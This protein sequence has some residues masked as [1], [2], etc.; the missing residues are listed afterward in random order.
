MK[1]FSPQILQLNRHPVAKTKTVTLH[2]LHGN[3]CG[4]QLDIKDENTLSKRTHLDISVK[5]QSHLVV[6]DVALDT[7]GQ[8]HHDP[9]D[10]LGST[11]THLQAERPPSR[12]ILARPTKSAGWSIVPNI[13]VYKNL[14]LVPE[15]AQSISGLV[16]HSL[17]LC[18]CGNGS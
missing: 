10:S 13:L 9:K 17:R 2:C 1:F 4:T 12:A 14:Y 7:Y 8:S 6:L 3:T 16:F 5:L 18:R 11:P 15:F